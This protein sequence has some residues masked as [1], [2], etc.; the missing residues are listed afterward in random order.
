MSRKIILFLFLFASTVNS[1]WAND[2]E[3]STLVYR[4]A[5]HFTTQKN[6]MGAPVGIIHDG[7]TYHLFYEYNSNGLEAENYSL[8]HATSSD[9]VHWKEQTVAFSPDGLGLQGASCLTDENNVLEKQ[10]GAQKTYVLAYSEEG[11]IRIAYSTNA[12]NSWQDFSSTAVISCDTIEHARQPKLMWYKE[13]QCY[14]L[15]VARSPR[16]DADA[17]GISFYS[18]KNLKDWTFNSHIRGLKGSPDLFRLPINGDSTNEKWVLSDA[19]GAFMLGDFN[20]KSFSALTSKQSNQGGEF[21]SPTTFIDSK[22]NRTIQIA[23]LSTEQLEGIDYCGVLSLPMQLALVQHDDEPIILTKKPIAELKELSARSVLSLRD[24]KLIPGINEN[25]IHR[26]KGV[27]V[28]IDAKLDLNNVDAFGFLILNSRKNEG[29]ELMYNAKKNTLSWINDTFSIKPKENKMAVEIWVDKSTV[30]IFV[31]GGE[32][33]ISTQVEP[34]I[35]NEKYVLAGQGGELLVK[36]LNA[37]SLN[38]K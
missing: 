35:G 25:P 5:Y 38:L 1:V 28:R 24:K 26:L 22:E 34:N 11:G 32:T 14:V 4:P 20:G 10:S 16:G 17:E 36:S 30:E 23:S 33:I 15:L 3:D 29:S 12:G 31:D 21:N 8:G 9:L 2:K 13:E 37:H 6:A 19:E 18:S 7:E 27:S